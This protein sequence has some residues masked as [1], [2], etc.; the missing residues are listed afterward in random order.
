ML[1]ISGRS[2]CSLSIIYD[3]DLLL[4]RKISSDI[5]YNDR[6]KKQAEKQQFL[7]SAFRFNKSF[8]VPDVRKMGL[9]PDAKYFFEMEYVN[10]YKFSDYFSK[11]TFSGVG[12]LFDT[13]I[14]YF[15]TS[16]SNSDF[17]KIEL[18]IIENKLNDLSN[19]IHGKSIIEFEFLNRVTNYLITNVPD[20]PIPILTCHGDMT[21]S[22]MLFNDFGE[23][24]LFD[25]LDSFIESPIIDLVKLRQDTS[26]NWSVLLDDKLEM[27]KK[28]RVLQILKYLDE[29]LVEYLYSRD[30]SIID[31][32]NYLEV[33]NLFRIV[34]YI[35]NENEL[36]FLLTNINKLIKLK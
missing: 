12:R 7:R 33:F 18:E 17:Q 24:F 19:K 8:I 20:A 26:L 9:T 28:T 27:F 22:N 21:F 23:I 3:N 6:L 2:G 25:F 16:F 34:P 30:Q 31:W 1:K 11:I 15:D 4:V 10:A 5:E 32:Y 36:S 13:L 14:N 35:H 29:K